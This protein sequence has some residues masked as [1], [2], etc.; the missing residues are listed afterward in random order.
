[1]SA[2]TETPEFVNLVATDW[3][4]ARKAHLD[5][6]PRTATVGEVVSESVRA[7]NLPFQDLYSAVFRGRELDSTDTLEEA[8][9]ESDDRLELVPEVSAGARD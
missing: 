6:V 9:V 8:G 2:A 3:E 7:L 1:M 4:G 5:G